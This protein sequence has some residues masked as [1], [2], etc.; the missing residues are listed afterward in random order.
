P[1]AHSASRATA[2][3]E[4]E[5]RYLAFADPVLDFL[6]GKDPGFAYRLAVGAGLPSGM[7]TEAVLGEQGGIAPQDAGMLATAI[8]TDLA[9]FISYSLDPSFSVVRYADSLARSAA[10]FAPILDAAQN[11]WVFEHLYAPILHE[12]FSP[13]VR[14]NASETVVIAITVPFPGCM[15]GAARAAMEAKKLLG[16]RAI[17]VLGGGYVSTEL[18]STQ[19][20]G[21]FNLFDYVA[22]DG[23]FGA[24][25]SILE[26]IQN[27]QATLFNTRYMDA[28]LGTMCDSMQSG[29]ADRD[30][31]AQ[32]EQEAIRTVHPD[33]HGAPMHSYLRV[34]DSPNPMHRLWNDSPWLKYRLAYGCYWRRCAF[35]DTQ[36]DYI[37][38]YLA[39]DMDRLMEAASRAA[40]HSGLR[41]IHF[42]DEAMPP[43]MVRDFAARNR[44]RNLPF[45]FWGN[46]RYDRA[47]TD[48]L[49]AAAAEGGLVAVSGGIEIAT[50]RGLEI[51]DKGFT[52]TELLHSLAAFKRQG[53]LTHGYLIYGFPG[54]DN[55]DIADSAEMVRMLL[56][57]GL[58]DSAF[59]HKFVL[60]RHSR[61]YKQWE[62]GLIPKLQPLAQPSGFALNDLRFAGEDAYDVWTPV[63]DACMAAWM[64]QGEFE[65]PLSSFL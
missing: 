54:Q 56:S 24:F 17:T 44:K 20:P 63:L 39:S 41:G 19:D 60:T 23:G 32:L 38:R 5:D 52:L 40:R 50:G 64:D 45:T 33:Y 47:W 7:R 62:D 21:F 13:L 42:V 11:S 61:M 18:R 31:Y 65:R 27:P 3:L 58:L 49:C 59:W 48:E 8:L 29:C 26:H 43:A 25:A 14:A 1:D 34:V 57:E 2:Y 4:Q 28:S 16:Q 35:C 51:V 36:L 22:Y 55:Q 12:L 6:S 10:D 15:A 9:D 53:I 37:K 30:G 46:A